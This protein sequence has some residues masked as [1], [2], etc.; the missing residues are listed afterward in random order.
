MPVS[1]HSAPVINRPNSTAVGTI[2]WLGS[3]VMFFAGLFA[4]YFSLR[5]NSPELWADQTP[6]L[7]VPLGYRRPFLAT[8]HD[9]TIYEHPEWFPAGQSFSTRRVVPRS[10]AA[11]SSIG[12]FR[13]RV[14]R[15]AATTPR[16]TRPG[17][18][19]TGR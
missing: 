16:S 1:Q 8:A 11:A 4:M 13:C 17:T 2:V 12:T 15:A 14:R 7:N 3:E 5:A 19:A 18:R 6:H 9:L 10:I